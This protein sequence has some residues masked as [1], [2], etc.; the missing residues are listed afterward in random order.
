MNS[1][2][3]TI[4]YAVVS[5][6]HV[7]CPRVNPRACGHCTH[8]KMEKAEMTPDCAVVLGPKPATQRN[9]T[10]RHCAIYLGVFGDSLVFAMMI[11]D[12]DG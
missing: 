9:A 1:H 4:S 2:G 11:D 8:Q 12:D 5:T 6:K 3:P 10:T 7:T